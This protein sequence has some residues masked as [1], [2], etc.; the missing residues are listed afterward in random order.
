MKRVL[1]KIIG[2]KQNKDLLKN[3]QYENY[4]ILKINSIFIFFFFNY[5]K[6]NV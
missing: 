5:I 3:I 2:H 1:M 6:I 4:N